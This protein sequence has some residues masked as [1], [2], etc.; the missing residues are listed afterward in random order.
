MAIARYRY[1]RMSEQK[2]RLVAN[3][4][5]KLKVIDAMNIL[6]F[7]SKKASLFLKKILKSVVSNS[8][9]KDISNLIICKL[10]IDKAPVFKRFK[11]RAKGR[12]NHIFKRN[13]HI[14]IEIKSI[15]E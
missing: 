1:V 10:M 15:E 6:E 11:A 5:R 8:K 3:Q 13:C 7:S 9:D 14:F 12:A 4:I 2:V